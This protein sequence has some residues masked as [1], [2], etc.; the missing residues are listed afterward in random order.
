MRSF[1]KATLGLATAGLLI[2]G[3]AACSSSAD[4]K[5]PKSS[6]ESS[7]SA[8]AAPKALA[9]IPALTGVDT[10]VL[11][12]ADFAAALTSLGLTPGTVGTATL[13][14][15]SLHFPITGGNVDYYDPEESY[16]PFV[17]GSI[18]HEGSG[19]SLTGGDTVVE[20]TNFTIDPGTSKLFGD[21]SVNGASAATQ[22]LLF[23]LY[24]GTLKP[25][26]MDGDNAILEG[27]TVHISAEA[28]GLLNDT[29]KT[30]AVADQ[31]LVGIAKITV[32]TK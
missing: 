12:D 3:L 10:A 28:A 8:E 5:T 31:L 1:T 16:R 29:F 13:T 26:Q 27:T 18:E 24:G 14:D 4:A 6:T 19:F 23:N 22:V 32:A 21:V 25:L 20:L 30:D 17:Q 11:L 7:S 2:A 9:S 15:G